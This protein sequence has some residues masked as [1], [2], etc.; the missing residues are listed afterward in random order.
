MYISGKKQKEYEESETKVNADEEDFIL[1]GSEKAKIH[2]KDDEQD[3]E[4]KKSEEEKKKDIKS[5]LVR[6][7]NQRKNMKRELT[8]HVVTRWYRAPELILLEKDYGPAI[9]LWSIGCIFA[10][11][12]GMMKE[13]APTY[14]D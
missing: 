3:E 9:D 12:L 13:N 6:T 14:L 7:K 10:E 8:G 11:L 5:R 1:G 4:E 2:H